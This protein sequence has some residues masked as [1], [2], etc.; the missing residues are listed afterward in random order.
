MSTQI[1]SGGLTQDM[2]D[3]AAQL[4]NDFRNYKSHFSAMVNDNFPI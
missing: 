3:E 4:M 2:I 1:A